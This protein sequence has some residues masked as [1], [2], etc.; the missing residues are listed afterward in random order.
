[1]RFR[2]K[3][4]GDVMEVGRAEDG[5]ADDETERAREKRPWF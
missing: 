1:M 4:T 2:T 5:T 3:G